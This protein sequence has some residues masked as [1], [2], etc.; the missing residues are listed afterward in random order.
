MARAMS[1]PHEIERC[2][3]ALGDLGARPAIGA[4][5]QRQPAAVSVGGG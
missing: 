2:S 3:N 4:Q 1:H 5:R